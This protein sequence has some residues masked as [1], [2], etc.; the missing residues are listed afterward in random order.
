[1][2]IGDFF[3]VL[4]KKGIS[5]FAG[6]P[7][8]LLGAFC[9]GIAIRHGCAGM[10][11][12]VAHN[13]GGAAALASGHYLATGRVPCVYMQNSGMGNALNPAVS[14]AHPKVH[15]IP[16]LYV[17]GWR[18]EPGTKDEPQH[19][20]Q[21]EV[22]L[23]LLE[24]MGIE[25]C[26]LGKDASATDAE[27]ALGRFEALFKAGKS[28][29]FVI[30]AGAF[31][32][33]KHAYGNRFDINR[34][35]A[36]RAVLEAAGNDPIISTTGKISREL[37]ELRGL[38][39]EGHEKDFLAIG[40]MGHCVMIALG[41]SMEHPG[42]TVWCIDGDGSVLMHMGSLGVVGKASPKN[43]IHVVLN[44]AAHETVGGMPTAAE[45][46]NL[47][48]IAAACGYAHAHLAENEKTLR[49]ALEHAKSQAGPVFIEARVALGSRA[50]LGR[51]TVEAREN[52]S[53]FMRFLS[54]GRRDAE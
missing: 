48:L 22:T 30:S 54:D 13:E 12:V 2:D 46:M 21:G 8:S 11:H 43:L 42:R 52:K 5:F 53:A 29:A 25:H 23:T 35:H 34:E 6:V 24:N 39:S 15:G 1:M 32:G 36:I 38:R 31:A 26:V 20:Y 49:E 10:R 45:G 28:A 19:A 9:D 50:D 41:V 3:S 18:G 47:V 17:I 7:D 33:P 14:L 16:I 40:S 51:P 37:F 4:D 27:S 44:N